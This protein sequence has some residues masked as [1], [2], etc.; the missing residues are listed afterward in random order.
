[1]KSNL[2]LSGNAFSLERRQ[3]GSPIRLGLGGVSLLQDKRSEKG[4]LHER[5]GVMLNMFATCAF[6]K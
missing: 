3:R 1:M 2:N 6:N 4:S 5:G